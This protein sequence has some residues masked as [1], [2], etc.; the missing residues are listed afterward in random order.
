M[1]DTP[2][3]PGWWQASDGSW[4]A[5]EQ[6][7]DALAAPAP[8][9]PTPTP[10]PLSPSPPSATPPPGASGFSGAGLPP[11]SAPVGSA[12][13]GRRVPIAIGAVVLVLVLAVGAWLV[14]GGGGED[15]TPLSER[16]IEFGPDRE[17]FDVADGDFV[18][19]AGSVG[20]TTYLTGSSEQGDDP[21]AVVWLEEDNSTW[22]EVSSR[23]PGTSVFGLVDFG[24]VRLAY[25]YVFDGSDQPYLA[26]VDGRRLRTLPAPDVLDGRAAYIDAAFVVGDSLRLVLTDFDA[27]GVVV[28]ETNDL[29][30]WTSVTLSGLD[31]GDE[32]PEVW[33]VGVDG[34]TILLSGFD[35]PFGTDAPRRSLVVWRSEDGQ[36]F[37]ATLP[38]GGSVDSASSA[39]AGPIGQTEGGW[40]TYVSAVDSPEVVA[41]EA[42][43][44]DNA[45]DWFSLDAPAPAELGSRQ[46]IGIIEDRLLLFDP[47]DLAVSA[48]ELVIG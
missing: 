23:E 37:A 26:E 5:P 22:T 40:F 20:D 38:P 8:P 36:T 47:D 12:G 10:T 45:V 27:G 44:S 1:S 14:V 4:Y 41:F 21:V 33:H 28:V 13:G 16:S 9:T 2:L 17:L 19:G 11:G 7:P 46:P 32:Q 25:G 34:S 15:P 48:M 3:G 35:R 39:L 42:Y 18:F 6:H 30:T 43:G 31:V 29:E 24:D